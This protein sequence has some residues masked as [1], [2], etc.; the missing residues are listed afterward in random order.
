MLF[1]TKAKINSEGKEVSGSSKIID[2]KQKEQQIKFEDIQEN[3]ALSVLRNYSAPVK[4]NYPLD[5]QQLAFLVA[6][7]SDEFNRWNCAQQLGLNIILSL[8][9]DFHESKELVLDSFYINTL[10]KV[11]I[12]EALDKALAARLLSLP[13]EDYIA[14]NMSEIDVDAIY[15]VREFCKQ[16]ISFEL[17]ENWLAVYDDNKIDDY[18]LTPTAMGERSLKNICLAYMMCSQTGTAK[19]TAI[20]RA[21]TQYKQANNM[22]DQISALRCLVHYSGEQGEQALDDFYQQWKDDTLVIDKWF[23]VQATA[24]GKNA[25]PRIKDLLTH[26]VFDMRVPNRIRSLI[27]SF[28]Q[29]NSVEFHHQ[30]GQGY[31]LLADIVIQ[32]NDSNPQIAARLLLPLIQWKNYAVS[33]Q[34]L[35]KAQLKRIANTQ[36]LAKDVFEITEKGLS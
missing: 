19:Q 10:K 8:I 30:S 36:N 34:N 12:D 2:I 32:L 6:N 3:T 4:L 20:E 21:K 15:K 17:M 16:T 28:S 22:T 14:Q 33:R 29:A 11:L 5:N 31:E 25:F 35:M 1:D 26:D 13:S 9:D 27:G 23:M 24:T 7:D 18:L